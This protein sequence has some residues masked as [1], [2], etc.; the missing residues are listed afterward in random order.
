M[1]DETELKGGF[2]LDSSAIIKWFSVEEDTEKALVFREKQINGEIELVEPDLLLYEV[3]NAL[4]YNKSIN[5]ND[6]K[7]AV[8]SLISLGV[9]IV[10]P[11]KGVTDEAIA[12]AFQYDLTIY[13]AYFVALAKVLDFTFITADEK[14]YQKLKRFSFVHL[15]KDYVLG[16]QDNDDFKN[17]GVV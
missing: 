1:A 4:R 14:L 15:L 11:T 8:D 5:E 3:A 2:I 6:V 9:D 16:E 13:D 17:Q 10:V 7:A 12:L